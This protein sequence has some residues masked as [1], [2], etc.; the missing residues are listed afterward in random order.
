VQSEM[1]AL[2]FELRRDPVHDG[3]VAAFARHVSGLRASDGLVI[4][5]RGP[6]PRLGL[7]QVVET[8]LFAIGREALANVQ[9]HAEASAAQVRVEA[10]QGQVVLEV[11]DNGRGFDPAAGHPGHF[12]LESMRSRAGEI[13]AKLTIISTPGLGTL[14]RVLVPVETDRV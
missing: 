7:S 1:R 5:V 8:Q 10:R 3:L 14:V 11:R 9:R 13:D 2:I 12:G 6:R 4:D